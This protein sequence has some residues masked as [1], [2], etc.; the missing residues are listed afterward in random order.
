MPSKVANAPLS[1]GTLF[2]P[3][4]GANDQPLSIYIVFGAV[5]HPAKRLVRSFLF[6]MLLF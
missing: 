1:C 3:T 6:S 2:A 4:A 5:K